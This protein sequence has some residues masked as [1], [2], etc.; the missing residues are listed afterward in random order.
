MATETVLGLPNRWYLLPIVLLPLWLQMELAFG[1]GSSLSLIR[2]AIGDTP[3]T[4]HYIFTY[5]NVTSW[6][7]LIATG[8]ITFIMSYFWGVHLFK[9][10]DYIAPLV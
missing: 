9:N 4:Y 6:I 1:F 5:A 10:K 2:Q 3:F 7:I 8:V